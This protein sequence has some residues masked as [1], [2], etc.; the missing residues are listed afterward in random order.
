MPDPSQRSI[1]EK[2]KR[3]LLCKWLLRFRHNLRC[4]Y[5]IEKEA[6]ALSGYVYLLRDTALTEARVRIGGHLHSALLTPRSAHNN[7]LAI[8]YD[9]QATFPLA[10]M[11]ED[12]ASGLRVE[13]RS[14]DGSWHRIWQTSKSL[15]G[16]PSQRFELVEA[17]PT[18]PQDKPFV[19]IVITC[20]NYGRYLIEAVDSVLDQTWSDIEIIVVDD[21]SP[22]PETQLQ[23]LRLPRSG[24]RIIRQQ[25][26]RTSKARNCGIA[27]AN[28][29]YIVML[30]GDDK[31]APTLIEKALL[32][33]ESEAIDIA[34]GITQEF[35]QRD[36]IYDTF[37]ISMTN[38]IRDNCFSYLL[39][40]VVRYGS[41]MAV[42]T[43]PCCLVMRTTSIG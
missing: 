14:L 16:I 4:G 24:V 30:D 8:G 41:K 28:G 13:G 17:D 20:Y 9:L 35:G 18:Y 34:Y 26:G 23:L 12:S 7:G 37:Q 32:R 29:K 27:A 15:A 39:S 38:M 19:S 11:L 3:A 36:R 21:G 22:E 6:V 42:S 25:N 2:I 5:I 33:L 43:S 31:L 1:F 10:H 40:I